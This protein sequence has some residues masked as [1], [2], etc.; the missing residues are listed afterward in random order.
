MSANK[1][2]EDSPSST[3][4][5]NMSLKISVI[6]PTYNKSLHLPRLL[7]SILAQDFDPHQ[8][9][10]IIV[11]DGSTDNTADITQQFAG[12]FKHYRYIYQT[13]QG[14]GSA[15]N[16]GLS[17]AKGALI[18]FVADDYVLDPTYLSKMSAVFEDD[19][20]QG[21]RPL[22]ASLG[23]TPVEMAM[24]VGMISVFKKHG[25]RNNQRIYPFPL[26]ISWGGASMTRR[27]VFDQFGP[28]LETFATGEDSEY[29]IRLGQA[30]IPIHIYNEVLF[31]IKN[32]TGFFEATRRLYQYGLNGS[33]L[34][35]HL[36]NNHSLSADLKPIFNKPPFLLRLLRLVSRP[37]SDSFK[38]SDSP[39][40]ALRVIPIAYCMLACSMI[41]NLHGRLLPYRSHRT[42]TRQAS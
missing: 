9:E 14:I 27:S 16:T 4:S 37:V 1:Q 26:L 42:S 20:V 7:E 17:H 32:R 10:V 39:T 13:N 40:Q 5:L 34:I 25:A 35:K 18:S 24:Y 8:F 41:G 30:G 6:V 23:N 33:Q 12:R 29:G 15:R 38:F 11:N 2:A 31:K 19:Q 21:V 3:S 22:F 28:F 36:K